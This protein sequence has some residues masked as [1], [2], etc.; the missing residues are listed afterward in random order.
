MVT[1]MHEARNSY[2]NYYL[3]MCVCFYTMLNYNEEESVI[4]NSFATCAW[5]MV[6]ISTFVLDKFQKKKIDNSRN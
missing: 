3:Y 5:Y 2:L 6:Y 1:L 4:R